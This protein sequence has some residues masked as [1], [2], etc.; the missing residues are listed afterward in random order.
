[1][2]T[3]PEKGGI[4]NMADLQKMNPEQKAWYQY[5]PNVLTIFR[6]ILIVPTA[7]LFMQGR[8]IASLCCYLLASLTDLVDGW[9]A[10]KYD[11][12]SDWGKVMDPLADKLLLLTIIACMFFKGDLPLLVIAI[13]FGKELIMILGGIVLF[14]AS[15]MVVPSNIVGKMGTVLFSIAVVLTFFKDYT[16]PIHLYFMYAAAAFS[17]FS[18]LQYGF[19]L[20]KNLLQASIKQKDT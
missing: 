13:V 5:P 3:A 10:R 4:G 18:M 11:M 2:A 15:K 12:I 8:S 17:I 1:M 7:V 19:F 16:H 9:I 14:G 20:G 6:L